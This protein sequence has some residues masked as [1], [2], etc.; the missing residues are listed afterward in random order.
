[1]RGPPAP[2]LLIEDDEN[3]VILVRRALRRSGLEVELRVV[4]D[5]GQAIAYLQGAGAY[6]DRASHRLP[7]LLLLDLKMPGRSGFEVLAWVRAQPALR[8]VPLVVLT[9]SRESGDVERAYEA[10]ASSYLVKPVSFDA[11]QSMLTVLGRYWI[12]LNVLP[13]IE[14]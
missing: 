9:S 8:H 3:D 10:G 11:L 7:S 5:G 6:A 14:P 12:E 13:E 4:R 1:M 2:I